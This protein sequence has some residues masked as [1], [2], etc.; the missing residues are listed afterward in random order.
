MT[1]RQT[2]S[3]LG[4]GHDYQLIGARTGNKLA[5]SWTNS[6]SIG[7]F[8]DCEVPDENAIF[9]SIRTRKAYIT[10]VT[11]AVYPIINIWVSG[12]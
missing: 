12:K 8:D 9:A 10:G 11:E 2:V 3:M 6:K 7:K 4:Y 5:N 1:V